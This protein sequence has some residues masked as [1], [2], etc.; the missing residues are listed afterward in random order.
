VPFGIDEGSVLNYFNENV[1]DTYFIKNKKIATP[2]VSF[3]N[4]IAFSCVATRF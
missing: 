4:M 3:L 2:S 1:H